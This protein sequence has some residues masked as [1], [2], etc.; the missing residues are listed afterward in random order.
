MK[1]IIVIGLTAT[2]CA[3]TMVGCGE[4][5]YE[6]YERADAYSVGDFTYDS[7]TVKSLEIDWV[8]GKITLVE[9]DKATLSVYEKNPA[10]DDADKVHYL[11]E[12]GALKIQYCKSGKW[13]SIAE[14]NKDL[15]VE[16][17][18]GISIEIDAVSAD[19]Q[20]ETLTA[21]EISVSTVSGEVEGNAWTADEVEVE[22]TSGNLQVGLISATEIS[23]ETTSG[24]VEGR[25]WTADEVEVETTSGDL[26]VGLISA[27]GISVE[28]TSGEVAFSMEK[29]RAEV[30]TVSG[31]VTIKLPEGVGARIEY[32]TVSGD[33]SS[34][35]AY[36]KER[37]I[38]TV[39]GGELALFVETSS[40]DLRIE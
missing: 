24:E 5:I 14:R 25:A 21:R 20:A 38:Y 26:Q 17:P 22:T 16:V 34:A 18:S 32:E 15:T 4:M 23:V 37:D 33:F 1:K 39:A 36:T 27:T 7:A 9:S 30:D 12:G 3:F 28:T 13:G 11:L 31:D 6:K 29:G 8:A 40:G 19:V 10:E 35:F 2:V